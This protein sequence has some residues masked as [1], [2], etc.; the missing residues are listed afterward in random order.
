MSSIFISKKYLLYYFMDI[1][2]IKGIPHKLYDDLTEFKAL[3]PNEEVIGNWRHGEVHDWV[4]TDDEYIC[5]VLARTKLNHPGYKT[6]RVMVRTICGSFIVEQKTNKMLGE[7]GVA[8]NIYSFSGNY[9]SIKDRQ[10]TR[11]LKNR[12]F[13]FARY[14]AEGDDILNAYKKAYPRANNEK[15]IREKTSTLLNK[16]GIRTMVKEEIKKIL[17]EEGVSPE[18][19][20]EKYKTI[21]DASDR[22]TDKLRSLESLAKMAGLFDTEKKQEQLTVFTGFTPEQMEALSGKETKLVAHKEKKDKT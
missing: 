10:G 14:V 22:D 20:I 2:E 8:E 17:A 18:W 6:P 16:K 4:L 9:N 5:Q 15:Y 3:C 1:K 7:Y 11:K 13:L 12:E 19:I 21:A